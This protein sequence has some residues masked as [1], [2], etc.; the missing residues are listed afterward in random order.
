MK[1]YTKLFICFELCIFAYLMYGKIMS[2]PLYGQR[3]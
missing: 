3:K 1:K 2:Y